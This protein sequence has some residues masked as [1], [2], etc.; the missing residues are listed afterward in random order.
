MTGRSAGRWGLRT[1]RV[2]RALRIERGL[3][4]ARLRDG[5]AVLAI[6]LPWSDEELEAAIAAVVAVNAPA[7]AAVRITVTR[8]APVG[9]GL[10][11]AGWRDLR[12]TVTVQAWRHVPPDGEL[13]RRGVRLVTW[14]G[15]RDPGHPL[16]AVKTIS[17]ADHVHAK[18]EAQRAR[19]DDA[20]TLT[21]DGH[22]AEATTSSVAILAGGRLLTP[23]LAAGILAGTTRDWLLRPEGAAS[24]GLVAAEAW[25]TTADVMAAEEALLC[26]SVAG[27]LPVV[28]LDGAPIAD[29]V[30][31]VDRRL[32]RRAKI[33][34]W[35][36][37][38]VPA[39][40]LGRRP[41][42]RAGLVTVGA[43]GR[44]AP[45]GRRP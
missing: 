16:A 6:H 30:R 21:L 27:A 13:L 10:L 36:P 34:T 44:P 37:E 45:A 40:A 38:R 3:H 20:L 41:R 39:A 5:L 33:W 22:V 26:S 42:P 19:A 29:G 25:L 4:L 28:A 18:L 43:I 15:R 11:P 12:P 23:P 2:R 8:G 31:V 7:D 32:G 9:R 24:L 1:L 17:R 14:S 35:P